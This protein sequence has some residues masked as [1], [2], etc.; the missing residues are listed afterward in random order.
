MR[1]FFAMLL[2]LVL[3]GAGAAAAIIGTSDD[4]GSVR[5]RQYA[6]QKAQDLIDE[7]QQLVEDNTR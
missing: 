3:V 4:N 7:I 2:V 6:G 1:R 5:L